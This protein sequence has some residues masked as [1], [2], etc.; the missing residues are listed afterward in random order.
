MDFLACM[1]VLQ[2][3]N[4][5]TVFPACMCCVLLRDRFHY[6][7]NH[8]GLSK[9]SAALRNGVTPTCRLHH[10]AQHTRQSLRLHRI[11]DHF[12]RLLLLILMFPICCVHC[13]HLVNRHGYRCS[14]LC[15]CWNTAW[16]C[17]DAISP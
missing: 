13:F 10:N 4:L 2:A 9:S 12:A 17:Q 6:Y 3:C 15:S 14:R 11:L 7:R 16:T 8:S 1:H 5:F